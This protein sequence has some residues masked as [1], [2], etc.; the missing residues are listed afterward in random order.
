M[1]MNKKSLRTQQQI[2]TALFTLMSQ[3]QYNDLSIT[4]ITHTAGVS[5][6]A[7]YRNYTGKDMILDGFIQ[8]EYAQ[9]M[10]DVADHKH[11]DLAGLLTVY[12]TYFV[13]HPEIMQN[14]LH[15]GLDGPIL[16]KQTEYF[17]KFVHSY[18]GDDYLKD[19]ELAYYSGGTFMV[20]HWW[21]KTGYAMPVKQVVRILVNRFAV[22]N[23]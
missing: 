22:G 11:E 14:L 9:F 19:Y 15:A 2:E 7:F 5:R 13:E 3:G 21:V 6:A 12:L 4:Q 10:Q 16:N 18:Y 17:T 23:D 8:K 1:L 20:L